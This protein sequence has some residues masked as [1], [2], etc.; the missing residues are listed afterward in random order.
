MYDK[1]EDPLIKET[2]QQVYELNRP[3][4]L[5]GE[6]VV[7][8]EKTHF[9]FH[10]QGKDMWIIGPLSGKNTKLKFDAR[11]QK[12]YIGESSFN[13]LTPSIILKAAGPK[14]PWIRFEAQ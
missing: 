2:K 13:V 14:R 8:L 10:Y 11:E 6:A 12:L 3:I 4:Y 5:Y 1:F 9:F 7:D